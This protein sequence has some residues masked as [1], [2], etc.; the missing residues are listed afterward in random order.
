M[1]TNGEVIH[2]VL[3]LGRWLNKP[4]E[5]TTWEDLSVFTFPIS[6]LRTMLTQRKGVLLEKVTGPK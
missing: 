5:E 2:Q 4:P 1:N 6:A 3:C